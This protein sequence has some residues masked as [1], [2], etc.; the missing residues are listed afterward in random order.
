MNGEHILTDSTDFA[1]RYTTEEDGAYLKRWLLTPG[2]SH[3]FS[4]EGD[5]EIDE[6][7]KIWISFARFT[8]SLTAT[9]QEEPCGIATLFLMPYVKLIHMSMGYVI[10]DPGK[11]RLGV[12]TALIKNLDHLG[13]EYFRLERMHYEVYGNNPLVNILQK[14][15]YYEVFRQE[16][17]V[18]EE[19]GYLQRIV[20]EKVF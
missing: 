19:S 15:G 14:E 1:I 8:C 10:V 9:Y 16:R 20:V 7:V 6:F 2:V 11:Q 3:W 5:K 17:Y 13:K 4:V 12:G 18:K